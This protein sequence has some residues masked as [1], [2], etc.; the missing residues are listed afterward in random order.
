MKTFPLF[1][2]LSETPVTLQLQ[3][4]AD[5]SNAFYSLVDLNGCCFSS[6]QFGL[7]N[8]YVF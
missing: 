3:F 5:Y 6:E 1:K 8:P 2:L 7:F 4:L